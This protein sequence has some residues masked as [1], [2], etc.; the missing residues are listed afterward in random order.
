MKF[1]ALLRGINVGGNNPVKMSALKKCFEK[2]DFTN[3]QTYIQSGNVIFESPETKLGT[4]TAK[5]EKALSK[6][7]GYAMRIV[8]VSHKQL[9]QIIK[10]IPRGFGEKPDQYR[11]DV[12]F[13]M[14]PLTSAKALKE[15]PI[16]EGVDQIWA[17]KGVVY[18]SRLIKKATQSKLSRIVGTPLYKSMSIRNWNT[19]SKLLTLIEQK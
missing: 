7:L 14:P 17:G 5:I 15:M 12:I 19:T 9:K 4:L 11:Y 18:F 13:L 6:E 3:V 8:L 10:N 16:K 1:V 2:E